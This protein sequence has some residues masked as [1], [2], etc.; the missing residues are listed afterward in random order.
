[1][2]KLLSSQVLS[3]CQQPKRKIRTQPSTC[4]IL[5]LTYFISPCFFFFFSCSF[6]AIVNTYSFQCHVSLQDVRGS[7]LSTDETKNKDPNI[8]IIGFAHEHVQSVWWFSFINQKEYQP[9]SQRKRV[10][11]QCMQNTL[12]KQ[13]SFVW[14]K[15]LCK[16]SPVS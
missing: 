3:V 6:A 16:F 14:E 2:K 11:G 1:M 7:R 15:T 12:M 5:P 9:S 13:K 8:L 10:T 4:F